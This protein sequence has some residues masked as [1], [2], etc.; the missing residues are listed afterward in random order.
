VLVD[1]VEVGSSTGASLVPAAPIPDGAHRWV[2]SA[3]DRRGQQSVSRTRR[4]RVDATAP[5]ISVSIIGTHKKGKSLRFRVTASDGLSRT[6]A[7]GTQSVLISFGDGSPLSASRSVVHRFRHSGHYT[8]RV[9][10]RDRVGNVGVFQK[11]LTI[12]K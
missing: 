11:R 5:A 7:S 6:R 1:G 3:T 8:I 4:L 9:S 2:V 12:R 10:A